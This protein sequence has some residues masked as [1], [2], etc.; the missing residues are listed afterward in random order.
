MIARLIHY[1]LLLEVANR[2]Q[3]AKTSP[4]KTLLP[5]QSPKEK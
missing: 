2:I 3:F 1:R 5:T 4:Q